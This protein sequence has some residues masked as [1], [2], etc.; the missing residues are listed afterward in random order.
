MSRVIL[1][2]DIDAFFA[3]AEQLANPAYRGKPV[4]VGA[5]PKQG[6][7]RGVVSTASYEARRFGVRSA[8]PISQAWRLCPQGIYLPPD[9]K[10]Y[11]HLSRM[12]MDI[13]GR[14]TPELEIIGIDEAFLDCTGSRQLFGTGADI[15]RKIREAVSAETGLTVSVGI[16]SNKSVAK[17]ASDLNKPDGITICPPGKEA[18]FL[19]ELDI[20]RLWGIGKKT[21][22]LLRERG[23]ERIGDIARRSPDELHALIGRSGE[24]LW[25]LANGIDDRAVNP[26][27]HDPKS[28]SEEHTFDEDTVSLETLE[29][30]LKLM[31]DRTTRRLRSDAMSFRTVTLKLRFSDFHTITR[32]RTLP[33]TQSSYH[34]AFETALALFRRELPLPGPVRLIGMGLS[35]LENSVQM[36]LFDV[37]TDGDRVLDALKRK[38]GSRIGRASLYRT[39]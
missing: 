13:L 9:F 18:E 11:S 21:A 15:A 25:L 33:E 17:I 4:I 20:G 27:A 24:Q 10:R 5:D 35:G 34:C 28:C 7:G 30:L 31:A 32:S 12:V 38:Y 23:L 22:A 6:N 19:A 2:V 29:R 3:S 14:F 36:D 26:E 16:A 37:R 8:Q 39:E 1:H